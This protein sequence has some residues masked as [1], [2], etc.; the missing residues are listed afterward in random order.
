MYFGIKLRI[1]NQSNIGI[2]NLLIF[3]EI[4]RIY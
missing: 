1:N 4:L 3:H 2:N